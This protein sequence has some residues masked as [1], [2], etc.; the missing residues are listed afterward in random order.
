MNKRC[1]I[2]IALMFTVITPIFAA[3]ELF[4]CHD[5]TYKKIQDAVNAASP[6]SRIHVCAGTYAEQVTVAVNDITLQAEGRVIV[7]EPTPAQPYGFKI[8]GQGVEIRGFEI[9]GFADQT[10]SA[11]IF[12]DHAAHVTIEQNVIYGN[13]NG[14]W[15]NGAAD[16]TIGGNN[17]SQNPFPVSPVPQRG[18]PEPPPGQSPPNSCNLFAFDPITFEVL[19]SVDGFAVKSID[20]KR[21]EIS[22]NSVGQNGQCGIQVS[23]ASAGSTITKNKLF[24]N[25]SPEFAPC[26]NIDV[27]NV[28]G[29]EKEVSVTNN[30]IV[31]GTNGVM[32][33]GA[34]HISVEN[35][36]ITGNIQGIQL[37]KS[38]RNKMTTNN[39]HA[40]AIGI[41]MTGN[42]NVFDENSVNNNNGLGIVVYLQG[43]SNLGPP[44]DG[45]TFDRTA[46]NKFT[47]N[48]IQHNGSMDVLDQS[49]LSGTLCSAAIDPNPT[50]TLDIWID[51]TCDVSI[52]TSICAHQP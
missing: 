10:L 33:T 15:L 23:G 19:V 50:R 6:G 24:A 20:G 39:A 11:G 21:A 1:P 44:V 51:N 5:R 14:V 9:T 32:L 31:N 27:R 52:P 42:F 22:A 26:G 8:L 4:V 12:V 34:D 25:G 47:G 43:C 30:R 28:S 13:C 37:V 35:N 41:F 46:N 7:I 36:T 17:I 18:I 40:N 45:Q 3:S 38:D 48:G 29:V 49:I 2:L 16:A